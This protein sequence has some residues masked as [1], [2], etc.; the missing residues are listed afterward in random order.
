M[1]KAYKKCPV[2]NTFVLENRYESHLSRVHHQDPAPT[3]ASQNPLNNV[4]I[5]RRIQ[6][7]ESKALK[8]PTPED[9]PKKSIIDH[10][11]TCPHCG[12]RVLHKNL[13]DHIRRI[14]PDQAS[15][16]QFARSLQRTATKEWW[17]E[18]KKLKDVVPLADV[19]SEVADEPDPRRTAASKSNSFAC[20]ICKSQIGYRKLLRHM[21]DYHKARYSL[22]N[23]TVE[24]IDPNLGIQNVPE[25][26]KPKVDNRKTCTICGNIIPIQ[27]L[28][29]HQARHVFDQPLIDPEQ[30]HCP[31]CKLNIKHKNLKN[32][33]QIIH[34]EI[35]AQRRKEMA[36]EVRDN[37]LYGM[38]QIRVIQTVAG[39]TEV[40]RRD[41]A[42]CPRCGVIIKLGSL[43]KHYIKNHLVT[44]SG[45]GLI[46]D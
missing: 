34:P 2:C 37:E 10:T 41:W 33:L 15:Y 43:E 31:I 35:P 14:H 19:F 46:S 7:V 21:A 24:P 9:R 26:K 18:A 36:L 20:P 3:A 45:S 13:D 23:G 39:R 17:D 27:D 22:I 16:N 38:D 4:V 44:R 42:K 6:P 40:G 29:R 30:V 12:H 11:T 8:T 32:H 5:T 28:E 25:P 1:A